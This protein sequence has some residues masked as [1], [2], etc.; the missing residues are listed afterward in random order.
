VPLFVEELTKS[1]LASGLLR[2][3]NDRYVLDRL[4]A[5]RMVA[6]IGAAIGRQFS[7]ALIRRYPACPGTSC[8]PTGRSYL[9]GLALGSNS[10]PA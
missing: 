1:V 9:S 8:R 2:E 10:A 4:G 3:E 5:A 6:Q 7:Y